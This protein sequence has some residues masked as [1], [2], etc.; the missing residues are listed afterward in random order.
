MQTCWSGSTSLTEDGEEGRGR[1]DWVLALEEGETRGRVLQEVSEIS[2]AL[3]ALIQ[4]Q[5]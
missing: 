2:L 4:T 3:F 5:S 1:G